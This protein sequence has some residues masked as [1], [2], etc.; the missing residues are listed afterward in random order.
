M[1]QV[2]ER[3]EVCTGL[4]WGKLRETDHLEDT[5]VSR[6]IIL[7]WIFRQWDGRHGLDRYGSEYV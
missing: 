3:K 2:W 6:R 5:G 4:W 1:Q 7:R